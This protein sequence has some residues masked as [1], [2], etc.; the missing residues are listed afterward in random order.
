M[1]LLA[2][3]GLFFWFRRLNDGHT[4]NG[5]ASSALFRFG[6]SFVGG[7]FIGW[8]YRKS[9]HI[10]TMM[11]AGLLAAVAA[12]K[13]SGLLPLDWNSVEG[14]LHDG[15]TFFSGEAEKAEKFLTGLLPSSF[16]GGCG[17]FKGVRHK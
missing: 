17:I 11:L 9:I 10:A 5:L 6:A 3:A 13:W 12:A 14:S 7:F 1:T 2:F 15:F 4:E 8:A 16:A